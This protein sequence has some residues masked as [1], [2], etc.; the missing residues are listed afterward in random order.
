VTF[1]NTSAT[2]YTLSGTG[3]LGGTGTTLDV[4]GGGTVTLGNLT[5]G[6]TYSGPTSV[7]NGSTLKLDG[8]TIQ[9]S[10]VTVT[11]A[12]LGTTANGGT[13]GQT[14]SVGGTSALVGGSNLSV[15]DRTTVTD[16]TFTIGSGGTGATL[17]ANGGLAVSGGSIAAES[18]SSIINIGSGLNYTSPT[19]SQLVGTLT[20]SGGLLLNSALGATLELL[21]SN[22][23]GGGTTVE[24]GLL[25]LDRGDALPQG[26][27]LADGVT[28][29][30][31]T[32][33]IGGS[34]SPPTGVVLDSYLMSA[35]DLGYGSSSGGPVAAPAGMA[36]VPEPGTLI[37]LAAG[38]ALAALAAWRR[39]RTA[40]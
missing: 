40:D 8:S 26:G 1:S 3:T 7:S 27:L 25:Q 5:G 15:T 29:A 22:S 9:S 36:A 4:N 35:G 12:N 14:L 24:S 18:P 17:N 33:Q 21:N 11:G 32:L 23:Y 13:L 31:E 34:G 28:P 37:L 30:G 16:G 19:G 39:K 2:S 6:Y 10:P 20:G 38:A